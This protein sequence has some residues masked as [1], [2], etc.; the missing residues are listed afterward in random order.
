MWHGKPG[1]LLAL[2]RSRSRTQIGG[3]GA[4]TCKRCDQLAVRGCDHCRFHGG[5]RAAHVRLSTPQRR[6]RAALRKA[7]KAGT[8]PA[9]LM[10]TEAWIAAYRTHD[11]EILRA[12]LSAWTISDSET[13]ATV[14]GQALDRARDRQERPALR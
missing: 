5:G 9:D 6:E 12:L 2:E 3:P 4:R 13:F 7:I 1:S 8:I 10:R 11:V 14:A